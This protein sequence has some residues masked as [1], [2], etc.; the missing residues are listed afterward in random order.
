MNEGGM[1]AAFMGAFGLFII[2]VSIVLLI[3]WTVLPFYIFGIKGIMR[4]IL[5]QQKKTNEFLKDM[6]YKKIAADASNIQPVEQKEE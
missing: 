3:V 6:V 1:A 5:E 4:E 2:I